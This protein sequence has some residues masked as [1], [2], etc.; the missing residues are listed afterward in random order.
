M[1]YEKALEEIKKAVEKNLTTLHLSDN[2]LSTLPP[3]I[4]ELKNLKELNLGSNKLSTLPPEIGE[5]KNLTTLHLSDNQLSTLPPEI[6]ELKNL[7]ELHLGNNKLSTL[8]A[9]I[10]ELKNLEVLYLTHNPLDTLP[11]AIGELKNLT[12]LDLA[13]IKLSKLPAEIGELKNLTALDLRYNQLSIVPAEIG[14]LK[15]LIKLDLSGNRLSMVPEVLLSLNVEIIYKQEIYTFKKGII[16]YDNPIETP[17]LEI[18]K[19]G[20]D[21]IRAYFESLEGEKRT[22]NE[23]KVLL[24][25]DGGA[26]KTSLVK[27]LMGKE[28]DEEELQTPGVKIDPWKVKKDKNSLNIHFW[29]FGGQEIMHATHQFFLSKRSLYVL[30]LD[31][32]KDEK[33]E[34]WLK[35]IE[36]FGGN[37]PVL[38]VMNKIDENPGFDVNRTFLESKYEGIVGFYRV[39]CKSKRG[40]KK[41]KDI[42][43]RE[44]AKLDMPNTP[45]AKSWFNVK[46]K[47]DNLGKEKVPFISYED[48]IEICTEEKVTEENQQKALAGFLNDLGIVVHFSEF[49]LKQTHVLEPNWI[50][51]GVYRIINSELVAET[52]GVLALDQLAGVLKKKRKGDADFSFP[53]NQHRYILE[54]MR[55]FELCYFIDSKQVLIPDLLP[56]QEPKLDFDYEKALG[57]FIEYDFLP[58]TVIPRFI[59]KMHKDIKNKLVWRTGVVLKDKIFGVETVVKCDEEEKRIYIYIGG[60][61]KADY[62]A[63][64]RFALDEINRDF[65]K[66]KAIEKVPMPDN[67]DI[68]VPYEHLLELEKDGD[69]VF[70][71]YDSKKKYDIKDLLG[72]VHVER[73]SEEKMLEILQQVKGKLEDLA[74]TNEETPVETLNKFLTLKPNFFGIGADFNYLINRLFNDDKTKQTKKKKKTK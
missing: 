56:V 66:F 26:G 62:L 42:L 71:P 10:G 49:D 19:Q 12:V 46:I 57:F 14:E 64:V 38:I 52:K 41:F 58:R 1:S 60:E 22:L 48:Y 20:K 6:G 43:V 59:V 69:R 28:F 13:D 68:S 53:G 24:V 31:G 67:P 29:D 21:A 5:F 25:G 47:L 15:N 30:V 3:E 37:S 73:E 32:R 17:P 74:L 36:A 51:T 16:L 9:E 45:W 72:R 44:A 34:Y 35:H 4:G 39:S 8:P 65:E 33:T 23:V 2:Q 18:V 7:K 70:R 54:L 50:T 61:Q 40:I 27:R 55:K 63:I 11:A